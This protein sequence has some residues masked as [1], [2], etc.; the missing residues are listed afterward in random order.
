MYAQRIGD[1]WR[2]LAGNYQFSETVFQS[3]ESLSDEQRK[4]FDIYLIVDAERVEYSN[5]QKYGDPIFTIKGDVVERRYPVVNKTAEEMESDTAFKAYTVRSTRDQKLKE[6]DW[7]Q[8]EDAGVDKDA[9]VV[10]RKALRDIPK[11]DG[12]PWNVVWPNTP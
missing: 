1:S 8:L 7:T 12:Y 5:V 6:S 3:A 2:E 9:W 11:Q 10:Y 4:E